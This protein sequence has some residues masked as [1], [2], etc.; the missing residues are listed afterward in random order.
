MRINVIVVFLVI[1][2]FQGYS[3]HQFNFEIDDFRKRLNSSKSQNLSPSNTNTGSTILLVNP[4]KTNFNQWKYSKKLFISL[5]NYN[6]LVSDA[7][8]TNTGTAVINFDQIGKRYFDDYY[9]DD[10][11]NLSKFIPQV[12]DIML[13]CPIY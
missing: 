4:T 13:L 1:C 9:Y 3:Q 12:P 10:K 7:K 8:D 5:K 6:L 2:T 11:N